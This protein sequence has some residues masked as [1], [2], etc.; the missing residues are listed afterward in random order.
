MAECLETNRDTFWCV[1]C[2]SSGHASWDRLCP[3]FLVASSC[4]EDSDPEHFY[5]YFPDQEAWTWEQQPG[6][7]DLMRRVS[8]GH[9]TQTALHRTHGGLTSEGIKSGMGYA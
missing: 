4:M 8:E 1:S 5:K 3:A 6:H 9:L 7:G 2:N